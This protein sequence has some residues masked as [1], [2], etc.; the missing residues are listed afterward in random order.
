MRSQL[1]AHLERCY[2]ISEEKPDRQAQI[3][4]G[5]LFLISIPFLAAVW[6][7][8]WAQENKHHTLMRVASLPT[9]LIGLGTIPIIIAVAP[10]SILL[11]IAFNLIPTGTP[12][13]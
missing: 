11:A 9:V 8:M 3:I 10:L 2:S 7:V 4:M 13:E 12:N 6:I 5:P 1:I